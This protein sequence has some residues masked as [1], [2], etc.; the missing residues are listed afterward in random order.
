MLDGHSATLWEWWME[1]Q[2]VHMWE[3]LMELEMVP[4]LDDKREISTGRLRE[5]VLDRH[6]E[7]L[8]DGE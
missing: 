8:K 5:W 7:L 2:K 6:L 3:L 4:L 1:R